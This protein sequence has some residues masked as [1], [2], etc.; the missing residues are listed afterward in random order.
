MINY[1]PWKAIVIICCMAGMLASCDTEGQIGDTIRFRADKQN[2][3][4]AIDSLYAKYPEY[5]VPPTWEKYKNLSLRPNSYIED[6][7]FYFKS[8]PEEMYYVALIDDSAMAGDSARSRLAIRAINHGDGKWVLE[9]GIDY[10]EEKAI[11]KRFDDEIV[12]K[13][14]AYMKVRVS[15]GE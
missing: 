14:K 15:K 2:L 9:S 5:K 4:K 3:D 11:V 1:K 10:K 8:Q 13:L 7:F 12:A 6:K